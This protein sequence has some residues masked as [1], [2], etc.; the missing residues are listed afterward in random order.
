MTA[1]TTTPPR[2]ADA[3]RNRERV[4]EA[5]EALFAEHGLKVQMS[6][7][8]QRAGVGVG[9]V[10]RNFPTKEA[11]VRALLDDMLTSLL[12]EARR[13]CTEPDPAVALWAYV[14]A[15]ADLQ[16]RSRGLAEEM[17]AHLELTADEYPI[18][19]ELRQAVTDLLT[20]A[21]DA[22][23]VRA[24]IG[25]ADLALLFSGIA[26]SAVLAGDVDPVQRR[27]Y[28]TVVLDGL[29]PAQPTPLPGRP[30]D[31]EQLE[32]ARKRRRRS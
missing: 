4:L 21:Q 11:L 16:T 3:R 19:R 6:E 31:F 25:P 14:E 30:L 22:G 7:V 28:L 32:R 17:A 27:R 8:A 18:K 20:R 10:C 5:A 26:H 15:M 29:R 1:A 23:A 2:R 24:D 12:A 13:A 9:T